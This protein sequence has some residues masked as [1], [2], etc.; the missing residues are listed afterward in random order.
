MLLQSY[1]VAQLRGEVC[2]EARAVYQGALGQLRDKAVI[3]ESDV[4]RVVY[5]M[6]RLRYRFPVELA[7]EGRHMQI[8]HIVVVVNVQSREP[9]VTERS[10]S[11][12]RVVADKAA[13]AEVEADREIS[14]VERVIVFGELLAV[15]AHICEHDVAA[16]VMAEHILERYFY[17]ELLAKGL[18]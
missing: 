6:Q 12:R 5:V 14:R 15:A 3:L 4:A 9:P 13:V 2:G 11:V 7:G 10:Y 1:H 17:P 16:V 18:E 8:L